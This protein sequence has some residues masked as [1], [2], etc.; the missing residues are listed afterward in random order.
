ME[1]SSRQ[2][3]GMVVRCRRHL[4]GP[5][6]WISTTPARSAERFL[7]PRFGSPSRE[8]ARLRACRTGNP[9][10]GDPESW[11]SRL[12]G[13]SAAPSTFACVIPCPGY[14][15]ESSNCTSVLSVGRSRHTK[16]CWMQS[17]PGSDPW[18]W[19]LRM[20]SIARPRVKS[21]ASAVDTCSSYRQMV[22]ITCGFRS[23]PSPTAE[24]RSGGFRM[25][26]M[27]R[28]SS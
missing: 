20:G 6:A 24:L 14:G 28:D 11:P 26:P 8:F 12:G 9:M 17:A 16:H 23:S 19:C 2:E 4:L 13:R 1:G 10:T 25:E 22:D 21:R 5:R 7:I 3:Y 18:N 15:S 27:M